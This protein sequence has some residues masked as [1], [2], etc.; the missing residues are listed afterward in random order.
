ML[1]TCLI[2]LEVLLGG[3]PSAAPA[4]PSYAVQMKALE[5]PRTTPRKRRTSPSVFKGARYDD[6]VEACEEE[7]CLNLWY[8]SDLLYGF[9]LLAIP[10][11]A[12]FAG[13]GEVGLWFGYGG[14]KFGG[15]VVLVGGGALAFYSAMGVAPNTSLSSAVWA[16]GAAIAAIGIGIMIGSNYVFIPKLEAVRRANCIKANGPHNRRSEFGPEEPRVHDLTLS[17]LLLPHRDHSV[18]MGV[19]AGFK[20]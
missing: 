19:S 2:A 10:F 6:M 12:A 11:K 16:S 1:T 13:E 7:A 5:A 18:T 20:F 4:S 3:A 14:M 17:P 8:Y 15:W 9:S